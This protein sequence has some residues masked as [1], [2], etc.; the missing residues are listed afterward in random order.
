MFG[1]ISLCHNIRR[2]I[3]I[4]L[5]VYNKLW[6]LSF[7]G[8][9]K[10]CLK[11]QSSF[12]AICIVLA[13]H[14]FSMEQ[15]PFWTILVSHVFNME[16]TLRFCVRVHVSKFWYGTKGIL[17]HTEHCGHMTCICLHDY[18]KGCLLLDWFVLARIKIFILI[19]TH[20]ELKEQLSPSYGE[21]YCI[22]S[23][24]RWVYKV[25]SPS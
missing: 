10:V 13:S 14:A 18:V 21:I 15:C 23:L 22:V 20:N 16:A 12:F 19:H 8:F 3:W 6:L 24:V 9:S 17:F 25:L 2:A 4:C 5:L 1:G 11:R 7:R